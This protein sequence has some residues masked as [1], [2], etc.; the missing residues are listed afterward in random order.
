MAHQ[1]RGHHLHPGRPLQQDHR[2]EERHLRR[3]R[4]LLPAN[5]ARQ[6][7]EGDAERGRSASIGHCSSHDQKRQRFRAHVWM[8]GV[9]DVN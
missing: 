8:V 4:K 3:G 1:G 9:N 5:A 2:Q 6:R 7:E